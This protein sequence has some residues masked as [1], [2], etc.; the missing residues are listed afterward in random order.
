[1][2]IVGIIDPPRAGV[3]DSIE[4]LNASGVEVKMIT[5][6]AEETARSIGARLGLDLIGKT[7][8][9]GE[10]IEKMSISE[11]E[12]VVSNV[13][14]FFRTSPR[15]KLNII[16]ALKN[17]GYI[18]G[19]TGDG[20]NDAVALKSADIGI[21]MGKTGTDV[22]KEAADMIL[23]DDNFTTIMYANLLT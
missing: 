3:T 13:A 15:H 17:R 20:V 4:I 9:S 16:K 14:V 21:A 10:V 1:M 18:V 6:D 2:G 22:S 12:S 11:L 8:L 5:G 7:C 23:V 19:M